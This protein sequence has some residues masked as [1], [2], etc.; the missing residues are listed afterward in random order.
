MRRRAGFTLIELMVVILIIALLI[1]ISVMV[2]RTVISGGKVG[3]T[4]NV[5]RAMD[6]L[7]NDVTLRDGKIPDPIV[8]DPHALGRFMPIIDGRNMAVDEQGTELPGF[9]VINSVGLFLFQLDQSSA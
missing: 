6:V 4:R 1:S 2:G 9:Q 3:Q 5:L 8:E 7:L